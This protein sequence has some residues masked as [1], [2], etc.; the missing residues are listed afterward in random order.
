M[1]NLG[2]SL[3]GIEVWNL[4]ARG[5]VQKL[6]IAMVAIRCSILHPAEWL[7][8][9]DEKGGKDQGPRKLTWR[10]HS[11]RRSSGNSADF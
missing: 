6:K 10:S 8:F 11:E 1:R 5:L 9:D 2:Q 3:R 4:V 7:R